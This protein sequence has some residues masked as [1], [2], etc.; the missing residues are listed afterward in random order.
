MDFEHKPVLVSEVIEG[1]SIKPSGIY[2]DGTVGGGGHSRLILE[3]LNKFGRLIGIDKDK[4]ALAEAKRVLENKNAT[5]VY[6]DYE[7]FDT[8]LDNLGIEKV[9]GI[10]IDIGVS[11]YQLDFGERGFSYH[12]D[13]PLDMRM[14]RTQSLT[15]KEIINTY[16]KEKLCKIFYEYAQETWAAR[17]SDFIEKARA[18]KEIET[19]FELTE[20]IKAA[21]PKAKRR[22]GGHP[23]RKVFQALR[24]ETNDELGV[25][26]RSIDRMISRL[27][28]K[29]RLCVITF[30]SLEDRIVKDKFKYAALSCICPKELPICSCKKRQEIRIIT[31]KAIAPDEKE[32]AENNRS[33][34]A[35]LRIAEKI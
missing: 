6:G 9:D 11:S 18:E 15:A 8:I 21:I 2:V 32:I 34:S 35:K 12:S 7:N 27:A 22:D 20:I 28:P 31:K 14:D 19:T 29:G 5:L 3:H 17:I 24:I 13:A 25:L 1:L 26:E 33:R 16:P 10:L 23:S 30:H 4:E